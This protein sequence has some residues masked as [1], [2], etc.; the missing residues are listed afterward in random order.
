[1]RAGSLRI[2]SHSPSYH[3][4]LHNR[5]QLGHRE[6]APRTVR[7][8]ELRVGEIAD[9]VVASIRATRL[10]PLRPVVLELHDAPGRRETPLSLEIHAE[11]C[12]RIVGPTLDV[13]FPLAL[14]TQQL[15]DHA[16]RESDGKL[17]HEID[18]AFGGPC[19]DHRVGG[20]PHPRLELLHAAGREGLPHRLAVAGLDRRIAREHRVLRRV[21]RLEDLHEPLQEVRIPH[22]GRRVRRLRGEDLGLPEHV[23]QRRHA[24]D[25]VD[26]GLAEPV[27]RRPGAQRGVVGKR[28][29]LNLLRHR[30]V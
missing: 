24:G 20:G 17:V 26:V 2:A 5:Q 27:D 11:R 14:H 18:A 12:D 8:L 7:F 19:V 15:R 29:L 9:E 25:A 1:M 6:E 4:L 28:I 10:E 30:V 13:G 16:H 23:P 21:A 22:T 3:Q